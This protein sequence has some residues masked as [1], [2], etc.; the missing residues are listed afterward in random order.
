[1]FDSSGLESLHFLGTEGPV[2]ILLDFFEKKSSCRDVSCFILILQGIFARAFDLRARTQA[3]GVKDESTNSAES[4]NTLL[5]S[6][7]RLPIPFWN[8]FVLRPASLQEEPCILQHPRRFPGCA[9]I[10]IAE[11][12]CPLKAM[13]SSKIFLSKLHY[14]PVTSN[15]LP[16]V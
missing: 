10:Y 13:F 8:D 4:T 1:M 16:H 11:L 6:G 14:S 5:L 9:Y 15:F 7:S 12:A 3:Q 2:P